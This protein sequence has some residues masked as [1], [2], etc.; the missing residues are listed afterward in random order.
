MRVMLKYKYVLYLKNYKI[1]K[2][3]NSKAHHFSN[4]KH[5]RLLL[6]VRLNINQPT[7][8]QRADIDFFLCIQFDQLWVFE[9]KG[10]L[11]SFL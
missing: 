2:I 6:Y 3:F 8:V 10:K 11:Y 1:F 7:T 4:R 5:F 9:F